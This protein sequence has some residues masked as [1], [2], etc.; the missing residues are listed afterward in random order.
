MNPGYLAERE[1][2]YTQVTLDATTSQALTI[3]SGCTKILIVPEVQAIRYR[4]DGTNPTATVGMP[5]AVGGTLEFTMSQFPR[6]KLIAQVAG[7]II[8][9]QFMGT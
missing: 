3:P 6:L 9:V 4:A 2:G 5:I 7:A 8:N 1:S